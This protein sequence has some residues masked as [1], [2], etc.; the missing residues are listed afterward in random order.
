MTFISVLRD[1]LLYQVLF[2]QASYTTDVDIEKA[3]D[4]SDAMY[5]ITS[6]TQYKHYLNGKFTLI[7]KPCAFSLTIKKLRFGTTC[8][9]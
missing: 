7:S 1:C 9:I 4:H 8:T 3:M 6:Y 2:C 5:M